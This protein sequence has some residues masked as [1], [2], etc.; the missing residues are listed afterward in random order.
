MLRAWEIIEQIP[1]E[2]RGPIVELV[3]QEVRLE[4]ARRGIVR[5]DFEE[6]KGSVERLAEAQVRTEERLERLEAAVEK[7]A[8]AQARTEARVEELAQAQARTE[9]AVER[10]AEAQ[11]RMEKRLDRFERTFET[12]MGAMGARWGVDTEESFRRGMRAIL[13]DVGFRVERYLASDKEGEVFGRPSSI[14]LDVVVRD[15][16]VLVL[17][18]KSSVSWADLLFFGR[19]VDFYEKREGGSVARRLMLSPMVEERARAL[20]VEMGVEVYT[21]ADD[22]AVR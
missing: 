13:E 17:E 3:E 14:E 8:E 20:A 15:G 4:V 2:L 10:L 21:R 12:W 11:A 7:L 1:S 18:I 22:L 16:K 6:L 19:K 9:V 5:E